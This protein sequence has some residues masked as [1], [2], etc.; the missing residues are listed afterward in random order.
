PPKRV[1][2]LGAGGGQNAI[3]LAEKGYEVFAV[4]REP[5]LVKHIRRLLRQHSG[6]RVKVIE[7]D[8]YQVA[9]PEDGFNAVCYWD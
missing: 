3:A 9:L 1:L 6:A 8:F 4:E 2:E 5:L 7:A